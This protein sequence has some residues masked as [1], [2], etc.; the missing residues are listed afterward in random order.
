MYN[1]TKPGKFGEFVR[2]AADA[3]YRY[4]YKAIPTQKLQMMQKQQ[5]RK[6]EANKAVNLVLDLV[7][8]FSRSGCNITEIDTSAASKSLQNY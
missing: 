7:E 4:V 1:P 2:W 6:K 8:Q 5:Q 3:E